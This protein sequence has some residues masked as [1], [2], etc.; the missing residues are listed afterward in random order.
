MMR[1]DLAARAFVT[2]DLDDAH[3]WMPAQ[4]VENIFQRQ[5]TVLGPESKSREACARAWRHLHDV[6]SQRH[7]GGEPANRVIPKLLQAR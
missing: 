6:H 2:F 4:P 7:A 3:P 5:R 1:F